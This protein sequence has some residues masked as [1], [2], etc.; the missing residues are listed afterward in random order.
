MNLD[1][2]LAYITGAINAANSI[3]STFN[4]K[5][6]D[7]DRTLIKPSNIDLIK[8]VFD[9]LAANYPGP[10]KNE[11]SQ[12]IN[13][14]YEYCSAYRKTKAHIAS[15][16]GKPPGMKDVYEILNILKP[17]ADNRQKFYIDK[18]IKLYDLLN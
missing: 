2:K 18:M 17:V 10:R 14:C 13:R 8:Q 11:L 16:S 6:T 5:Y 4:S 15:L 9:I 12:M 1:D 3:Q 7:A